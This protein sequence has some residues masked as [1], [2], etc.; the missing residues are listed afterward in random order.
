MSVLAIYPQARPEQPEVIR[1]ADA[2]GKRLDRIGVRF[3]RWSA[4]RSLNA[5]ADQDAVLD[6]YR[7]SVDRLMQSHGFKTADVI[8]V[9]PDFPDREALRHKFLSEHTHSEF[10]VRF[11]VEGRGLFFLH[12]DEDVYAVLCEKGDLLSVPANMKHWFDT[13]A[14]PDLKA[15]RLF[16]NPE[17]WVAR[18]TGDDIADGLPK[19]ERFLEQCA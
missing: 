4:N 18:Y 16:T 12:P 3:E 15:I 10:E 13:G 1:D 19:M 9:A 5:D 6:A 7:E 2:I 8:S 14:E 11:F 17:G